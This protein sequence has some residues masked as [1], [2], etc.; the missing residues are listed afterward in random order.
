MGEREVS[1]KLSIITLEFLG[2]IDCFVV[3]RLGAWLMEMTRSMEPRA[4]LPALV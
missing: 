4:D 2:A 3:G 1:L